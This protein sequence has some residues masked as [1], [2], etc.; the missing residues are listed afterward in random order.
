MITSVIAIRYWSPY[1]IS[2]WETR[3]EF[4]MGK[5]THGIHFEIE[6]K[7]EETFS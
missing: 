3:S 5:K 1:R 4:A 6:P 2:A 7:K